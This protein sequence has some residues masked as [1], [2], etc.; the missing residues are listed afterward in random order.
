MFNRCFP[1]PPK[2]QQRGAA[3][4]IVSLVLL[5]G[6]TLVAFFVNRGMIFEQRTSANQYRSTVAFEMAEAGL[7]WAVARL[8]DDRNLGTAPSCDANAAG[9]TRFADRYLP[10]TAAGFT[11]VNARAGCSVSAATG[12]LTC[13]CPT[14]GNAAL[15]NADDR[16]FLVELVAVAG[17]PWAVEVR[18]F[19]CTNQGATCDPATTATPDG[20]A[21]VSALYKMKPS[22]PNAPGAGLVTGSA[23]VTG[24]NLNVISLDVASNGIT[25]N[26]GT[27]VDLGTG[28]NVVTLPGTP[29]RASVLDNDPSLDALTN[30]DG[31]GD[32]FFASFFGETMAQY[33]DN[34]KTY[35]ITSGSCGSNTRCSS[36][37]TSNAC[38]SAISAAYNAGFQ[39]FWADTDAAFGSANLPTV[40]TLGTAQKPISIA[41]SG[42]IELKA[43]ITAYGMLY[44][45]TATVD[46][47][48]DYSGSGTAKVYGAFVS[49]GAF[50]KGSGT[51]DLIY[52]ANIFAP[53]SARGLMVRVPGSWRDKSTVY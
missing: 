13:G 24:G 38:G 17:D 36:C 19:G 30:A 21:V 26:S 37:G 32:V 49:R 35:L 50:N 44:A 12:A 22:F 20:A 6:M 10:M 4:L 7:E 29:P 5:F 45:A 8:N 46:D 23:A 52:D 51:L 39:R 34:P 25:I 31:T 3:A 15:G 48:W 40:G 16:R 28:T 18:S 41:G 9:A 11:M 42:S 1:L 53:A 27:T 14:A 33:Q 2:R 43:N 47:E